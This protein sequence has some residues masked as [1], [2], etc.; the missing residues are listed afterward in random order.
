[1]S[2]VNHQY[3]NILLKYMNKMF[4]LFSEPQKYKNIT[5]GFTNITLTQHIAVYYIMVSS[6]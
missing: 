3:N 1:M 6:D 2:R 5:A 4:I